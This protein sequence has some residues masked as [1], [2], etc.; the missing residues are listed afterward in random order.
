MNQK[1]RLE[2]PEK[3]HRFALSVLSHNRCQ[4]LNHCGPC[5]DTLLGMRDMFP[6]HFP[7]GADFTEKLWKEA[8]IV[9]DTN[10]LID[11]HAWPEE[12]AKW[13]LDQCEH[14]IIDRLWLPNQIVREFTRNRTVRL[15]Q[16]QKAIG[17]TIDTLRRQYEN[18]E[19]KIKGS[20]ETARVDFAEGTF[21]DIKSQIDS[22]LQPKINLLEKERNHLKQREELK[23]DVVFER[24]ESIYRSRIGSPFTLSK[25]REIYAEGARRYA[26]LT[27]PGFGDVGD[28]KED[29]R[30]YGDLFIWEQILDH[31]QTAKGIIFVTNES[32]KRDWFTD[33]KQ[34]QPHPELLREFRIRAQG[35]GL[36]LYGFKD[37]LYHAEKYNLIVGEAEHAKA[38]REAERDE[39]ERR[40]RREEEQ[41]ELEMLRNQLRRQPS[42]DTGLG[43]FSFASVPP[44]YLG[45]AGPLRGAIWPQTSLTDYFSDAATVLP[46]TTLTSD[47]RRFANKKQSPAYITGD[48]KG[49]WGGLA[50]TM[51]TSGSISGKLEPVMLKKS[52]EEAVIDQKEAIESPEIIKKAAPES[53]APQSDEGGES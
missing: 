13:F 36:G 6:E 49:I 11:I 37:F 7:L 14:Q 9:F 15:R 45:G 30:L 38:I 50:G 28:K 16:R 35:K 47:F 12:R 42:F 19:S 21:P 40:K 10:V 18:L 5:R 31:A 27:P 4:V 20:L 24:L 25:E 1:K 23:N 29:Y 48:L 41:A 8:V 39:E 2:V 33:D 26:G 53:K 44:T 3:A 52:E 22:W 32:S 43:Q 17:D 51:S 34:R 46:S